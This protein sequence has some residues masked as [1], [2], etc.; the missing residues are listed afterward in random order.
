MKR[1]LF[2]TGEKQTGKS[3]LLRRLVEAQKLR[4]A[5]LETRPLLVNG[6]RRGFL[7]HSLLPMPPFENDVVCCAR[8][9]ERRSVPVL[10]AF[11]ENGVAMLR[12]AI[13]A[14]EPFILMDELGRLEREAGRFQAQVLACLDCGKPVIG[15]L[16]K[17]DAPLV[18]AIAAR[19]DVFVLTVTPENR[20]ALFERLARDSFPE[21]R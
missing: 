1:H 6:E 8:V 3:T 4:C 19:E 9:G 21:N 16:Q 18:A 11:E 14:P 12:A 15:V 17:C 20:D 13:A 7:L 10:P 5:G 2:L